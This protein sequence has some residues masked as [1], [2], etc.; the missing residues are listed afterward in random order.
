MEGTVGGLYVDRALDGDV[1]A[2]VGGAI[3]GEGVSDER[4]RSSD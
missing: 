4:V 3:E 1:A 2:G